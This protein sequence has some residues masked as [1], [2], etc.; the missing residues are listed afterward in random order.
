MTNGT[1]RISALAYARTAGVLYLINIA[2][3]IFGEIFVRGHLVV[4]G[5]AVATAHRIMASEFLFRCGI[6]GDLIMHITDVPMTVIFYVLLKPVSKDLSL[7]CALFG[8]LQTAILCAN[9]LSLVTVLLVLGDTSYLTAFDPNQRQALASLLLSLH[10]YAFGVG[11][12]FFGVSCLVAGYLMFRSGYFPKV[13]GLLQA[14]SGVCYLTNSF[15]QLL[16][17]AL[18]D[19]VFRVIVMPAF[20]GEFGTCLWLMGRGLNVSKWDERV[21]MGPV[22]EGPIR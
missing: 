3:G 17:P 14:M 22:I 1:V 10:E 2:C 19:K 15:G 5:D 8:I 7:L 16:F 18:A 11:L 20:I 9:K 12:I 6:A 13:L 21:R 4:A